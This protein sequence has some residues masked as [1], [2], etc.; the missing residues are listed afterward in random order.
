MA[1]IDKKA[2]YIDWVKAYTN[3]DFVVDGVEQIPMV[4]YMAIEEMIKHDL[5]NETEI[6]SESLGDYSVTFDKTDLGY[7]KKILAKL[8]PYIKREKVTF[9]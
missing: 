9:V 1:E 5:E 4:V 7:S 8:A 2:A 6:S 3:N